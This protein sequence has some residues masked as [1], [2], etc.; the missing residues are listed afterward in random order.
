MVIRKNVTALTSAEKS[1]LVSAIKTI[2]ANGKYDQHVLRHALAPM[3][4]IHRSPAF[5]PWHRFF[6]P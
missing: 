2:K 3:A 6:Y 1:E 5:L 4:A